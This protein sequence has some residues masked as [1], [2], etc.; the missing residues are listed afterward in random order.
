MTPGPSKARAWAEAERLVARFQAAGA[1]PV[2]A[3]ILQEA[4]VLLDLY[5][6]DIRG[7]AFVTHDPERGELMLRPDFTVPVARNHMAEG[8][9]PAR[10]TYSGEVFRRQESATDRPVEYIQVGFEIFG[11]DDPAAAEAEV[12]ATL[13]AALEG[14][15]LR[16]AVGDIGILVAAVR[17]LDTTDDRKGALMRHIWRPARFRALLDRFAGRGAVPPGRM[18]L[19]GLADP[20]ETAGPEIGL[21]SRAEIEARIEALRADAAAPPVDRVA[22]EEI[23]ALLDISLPLP[24]AVD[25]LRDI[26][27]RLAGLDGAVD[28]LAR[29][30]EA[31]QAR[32]VDIATLDFEGG[33]G[34]TALEYYDGFVFG[35]YAEGR[36]DLPPVATGGRYDALTRALGRGREVPT[37][38]GVIRPDLL[39]A[40]P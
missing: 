35:L 9:D 15:D 10:Y 29:R 19:L 18:A 1:V 20:F 5:G 28:R 13:A 4:H 34:R 16:R 27:R 38:G 22:R 31:L 11:G 6:E 25:A 21:R 30:A 23:D 24:R 36:P 3:D 8:A 7:R 26:A 12:F 14:R 32:G 2:E 40:L 17:G 37:V 39:E 33:Y